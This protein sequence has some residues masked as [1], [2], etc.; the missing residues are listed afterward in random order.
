MLMIDGCRKYFRLCTWGCANIC[1]RFFPPTEPETKNEDVTRDDKDTE[2]KE[3]MKEDTKEETKETTGDATATIKT[4][5][6]EDA[7]IDSEWEEVEGGESADN[8]PAAKEGD[9]PEVEA[10]KLVVEAEGTKPDSEILP[11]APLTTESLVLPDVPATE[12]VD[13]GPS[14]KKQ[15]GN[16][17]K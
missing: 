1:R 2:T 17:E 14:L 6:K 12:P 16:D 7:K 13:Q 15:K 9:A 11:D 5:I 10:K 8:G 4:D 3:V